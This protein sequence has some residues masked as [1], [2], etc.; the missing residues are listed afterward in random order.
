NG[1]GKSSV[2][3]AIT[4]SLFGKHTRK[5]NKNLVRRA[6]SGSAMVKMTFTLNSK[7]FQIKRATNESGSSVFSQLELVSEAGKALN[8][9]IAG[10]ER[11]QF[12]ES[13]SAEVAKIIGLDYDKM[14]VAALVQQG[15]LVKIIEA[16]PKEFKELLNGLIGIDRLDLAYQ[17]MLEVIRGFR[18]RLRDE[19]GY[20]DEDIIKVQQIADQKAKEL[21]Q[22]QLALAEFEDEKRLLEEKISRAEAEIEKLHFAA[23]QVSELAAKESMLGRHLSEKRNSIEAEASKMER[24]AREAKTS[25]QLL[26]SRDE[27]NIRLQMVNSEIDDIQCRLVENEGSTGQLKGFLQCAG[28]LQVSDG[29]CPVCSS[30]VK[31]I[32]EMFDTSHIQEEIRK[33]EK[34]KTELQK[35]K[36]ELAR[37]QRQLTDQDRRIAAAEKFLADNSINSQKDL[38]V[39]EQDLESRKSDLAKL[40]KEILKID[41]PTEL[42]IDEMSRTLANEILVLRSKVL[43]FSHRQYTDAKLEKNSLS[44]KLLDVNRRMGS[45]QKAIEDARNIVDSSKEII[46]KLQYAAEL[47]GQLDKIRSLVFNRDGLVGTSLRS[48][49]L[50]MVSNKASE[51]ASM[52][53]IG[54]SRI[55]LSEKARE[56]SITCYGRHGEIDMPSMSGGEKVAVALAVRLGI[57]YM[58]GSNRLDFVILDEPTTHLDEE[59]RKALV[60]IISEAFREGA[61]PLSQMI[62]ITHDS[63]IF[64]DSEVDQVLR[65]TM[66][67]EGSVVTRE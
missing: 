30:P 55:D 41:N 37:E 12:G 40:P 31:K 52:F 61:G 46:I 8:K 54:V 47:T 48:W 62:I 6:G 34:E 38:S 15:E 4:Y 21:V 36:V 33:K 42:A 17:T 16:Q 67:S 25:L 35:S 59:R 58:M 57:A 63:E 13:M 28:R 27:T 44:Q 9:K 10:G 14:R 20:T 66:T 23:Q 43:G 49:A 26:E 64:E 50:K 11:K 3:D 2:I 18:D 1:S 45:Y 51:Y 24:I 22:H 65:F 53:N 19:T 29:K 60:K 7:E 32:N 39:L 5:S 56:I